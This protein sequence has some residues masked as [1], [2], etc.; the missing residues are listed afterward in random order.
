[1]Y[2]VSIVSY[3]NWYASGLPLETI[4]GQESVNVES[5]FAQAVRENLDSHKG[6]IKTYGRAFTPDNHDALNENDYIMVRFVGNTI[7]PME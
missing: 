3:K 2:D 7:T 4:L 1:M 6:L 5:S